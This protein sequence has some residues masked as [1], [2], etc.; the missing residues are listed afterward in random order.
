M[1]RDRAGSAASFAP[2]SV[3]L[4]GVARIGAVRLGAALGLA[5]VLAACSGPSGSGTS[6]LVTGSVFSSAPKTPASAD[7]APAVKPDDPMARP[8]NV[9]WTSARA[10]K[11]GFYFDPAKLRQS[12]L[13][14]QTAAGLTADQA[15][16]SQ[17]N[18][19]ASYVRVTKA[20]VDK[21]GY[22]TEAQNADI[23]SDL[24]RHLAGDFTTMVK[25]AKGPKDPT[26]WEKLTD[27][28]QKADGG[29]LDTNAIMF[30]SGGAVVT[31]PR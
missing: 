26:L 21:E 2:S 30:P 28:G 3:A 8:V 27:G 20:L 14:S 31:T 10:A 1:S 6:S 15:A 13:A 17:Q 16:K 23:K 7:G 25:V 5:A 12:F 9:A 22:C 4:E 18:Y 29:T 24:T 19:D 11:C